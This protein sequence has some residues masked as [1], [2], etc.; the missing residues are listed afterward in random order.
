MG[1]SLKGEYIRLCPPS[2]E[3]VEDRRVK[4]KETELI[5]LFRQAVSSDKLSLTQIY[6]DFNTIPGI[7][8]DLIRSS[9]H[10]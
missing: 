3:V 9:L 10:K 8:S 2:R 4:N 6:A 7:S 1:I 5:T